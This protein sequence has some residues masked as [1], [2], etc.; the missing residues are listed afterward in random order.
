MILLITKEIVASGQDSKVT[1]K[2]RKTLIFLRFLTLETLDA[3]PA[4]PYLLWL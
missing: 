4:S 3:L 1:Q 2:K